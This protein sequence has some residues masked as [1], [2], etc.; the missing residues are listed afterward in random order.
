MFSVLVVLLAG[1]RASNAAA[2]GRLAQRRSTQFDDNGPGVT[3]TYKCGSGSYEVGVR[4]AV[5]QLLAGVRVAAANCAA[6]WGRACAWGL[7]AQS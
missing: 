6:A 2:T 3:A 7:G 4:V 1:T 5:R